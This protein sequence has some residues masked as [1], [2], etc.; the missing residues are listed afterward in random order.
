MQRRQ[1]GFTLVELAAVTVIIAACVTVVFPR[2][3]N[4]LFKQ[5]QLRS[6]V[7]RIASVAEYAHQR[8]V[9]THLAHRLH[10]NVEQ[11]TYGVTAHGPDGGVVS[12]PDDVSLS[13]RLPED[14]QFTCVEFRDVKSDVR[15]AATI[16]FSPQGWME[17]AVIHV[18]TREGEKMSIVTHEMLG[19]VEIVEV[20]E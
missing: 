15:G 1:S 2:L 6:V 13:G 7:S 8:A 11:G 4:G 10:I 12:I 14:V 18:G 20:L 16:E 9:Y 19:Y 3:F 5:Q 17:P